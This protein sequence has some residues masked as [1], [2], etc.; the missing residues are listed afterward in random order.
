VMSGASSF[1]LRV[2][3]MADSKITLEAVCE[4]WRRQ[5]RDGGSGHLP[6]STLFDLMQQ[7]LSDAEQRQAFRHLAG[8][9]ACLQDLQEM[10]RIKARI[11]PVKGPL[12]VAADAPPLALLVQPAH[13]PD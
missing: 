3:A 13:P 8:C 6:T 2:G 11:L 1:R 7:S 9:P 4:A 10:V 5:Q 12:A